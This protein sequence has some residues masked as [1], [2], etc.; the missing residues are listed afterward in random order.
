M[1]SLGGTLIELAAALVIAFHV[2]WALWAIMRHQGADRVRLVIAEG[3]LAGLSFSVAGT[4][5][6]AIALQTWSQIGMFAF[7]FALRAMLKRVFAAERQ[8]IGSRR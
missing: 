2:A 8:A 4:L 5:L 3:V 6:K 1:I 7:V